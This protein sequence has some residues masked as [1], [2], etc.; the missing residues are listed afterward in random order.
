[1]NSQHFCARFV[2]FVLLSDVSRDSLD[3]TESLL[4]AGGNRGCDESS[5]AIFRDF[6]RNGAQ[7]GV[8][9]F[10]DVVAAGAVNV[11]VDEAGNGCLVG[12]ANFPRPRGQSHSRARSDGFN[13]VFAN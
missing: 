12:C 3:R 4:R 7:C 9:S 2:G 6:A 13:G 10:H 8:S 1:M 11:Y 5:G